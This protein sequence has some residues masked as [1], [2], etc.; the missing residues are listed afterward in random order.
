MKRRKAHIDAS[1]LTSN[2][3]IAPVPTYKRTS[4]EKRLEKWQRN[5]SYVAKS[6]GVS[7]REASQFLREKM[8]VAREQHRTVRVA[9]KAK[10]KNSSSIFIC[11]RCGD[12]IIKGKLKEHLATIHEMVPRFRMSDWDRHTWLKR[13]DSR[14]TLARTHFV[15][16]GLPSLGKRR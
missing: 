12:S 3:S 16:G 14:S 10:R 1:T 7:L 2:A 11:P 13:G 8:N 9:R 4:Q 15:S 5:V 6:H